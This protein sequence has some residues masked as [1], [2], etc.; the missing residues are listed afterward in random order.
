MRARYTRPCALALLL[1]MC[2]TPLLASCGLHSGADVIAFLRDGALWTIQSDGSSPMPVVSSGVDGFA[3]SPDHHQLV[4]RFGSDAYPQ[5]PQS[6]RGAPDSPGDLAIVSVNGGTALQITPQNSGVLRSDAWWNLD[7]NRLIYRERL[8][9]SSAPPTYVV[10]QADQP[11]GIARKPVYGA[12]IPALSPDGKQVATIDSAGNVRLGMPGALGAVLASGALLTLPA[13]N[14]PARALWQPNHNALLY[15][16]GA[17][18]G[19]SLVL[20]DLNDGAPARTLVTVPALLDAAFSPDGAWLLIRTPTDFQL[21]T[22]A[23]PA[24][25][26]FL[27][28][29][30]DPLALPWWA[31]DSRTILV[32]DVAGWQQVDIPNRAIHPLLTYGQPGAAASLAADTDWHPAASSPFSPDSTRIVFVAPAGSTWLGSQLPPPKSGK[33]GLYVASFQHDSP[34]QPMLIDSGADYA[35]SWGYSAPS[36]V[37]LEAS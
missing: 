3:W 32:R 24:T 30:T 17:S 37:F 19:V 15:A 20:R 2:I 18:A 4:F 25:Q 31:P 10:S 21:Y 36:T 11:V 34:G 6:T 27:W 9:A 33:T 35:P 13:T 1:L 12:T 23:T 29:E 14:R 16:T 8:N 7:G 28:S 26:V 5:P 22:V